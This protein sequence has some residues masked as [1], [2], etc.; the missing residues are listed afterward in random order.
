MAKLSTKRAK[1]TAT[2][3]RTHKGKSGKTITERKFPI[4]DAAHARNAMARIDQ[5]DLSGAEKRKVARKART[6]IGLTPKI[7][8]VLGIKS[9]KK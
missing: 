4:P 9:K 3:V 2:I 7:R 5:S 8:Q 6:K 1:G